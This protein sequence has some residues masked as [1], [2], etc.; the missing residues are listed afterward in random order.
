MYNE[1][2][3]YQVSSLTPFAEKLLKNTQSIKETEYFVELIKGIFQKSFVI[4][5]ECALRKDISKQIFKIILKC[6]NECYPES[7]KWLGD[8]LKDCSLSIFTIAEK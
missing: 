8:F 3:I 6:I 7:I 2:Y 1:D 5:V 4:L